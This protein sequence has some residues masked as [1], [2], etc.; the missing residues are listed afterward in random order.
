MESRSWYSRLKKPR[1]APPSWLFGPVW[2]VLYVIIA[3]SFGTVFCEVAFGRVAFVTALPFVFNLVFNFAFS[4]IQFRLQ[5]NFLASVDILL[6]V[7]TLIWAL[8]SVWDASLGLRWV[9][10]ANL[11]YLGWGL[12]ATWLQITV[13]RLNK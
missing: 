9:F 6:V 5:N 1:W 2:T 11:P 12:F 8:L 10:Y 13:T 3:I 7:G 4:P